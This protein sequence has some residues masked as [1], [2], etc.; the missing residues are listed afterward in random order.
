MAQRIGERSR[1]RRLEAAEEGWWGGVRVGAG[2][3]AGE[4]NYNSRF[5]LFPIITLPSFCQV[6]TV[7]Q[8]AFAVPN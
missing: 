5:R 7:T 2:A 4:E 3:G 1:R 6:L 8:P